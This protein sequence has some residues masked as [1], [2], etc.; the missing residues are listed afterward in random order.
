MSTS[1]YRG[2]LRRMAQ[3]NDIYRFVKTVNRLAK[4][5]EKEQKESQEWIHKAGGYPLGTPYSTDIKRLYKRKYRWLSARR[6]HLAFAEAIKRGYIKEVFKEEGTIKI[7]VIQIED[8]GWKLLDR[9]FLHVLPKGLWRKWAEENKDFSTFTLAFISG[10]VIGGIG[11]A[12][13]IAKL[14]QGN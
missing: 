13:A 2:I 12:V 1:K 5:Q 6:R 11:L 3:L 14:H 4:Q 7:R 8:D 9:T 10:V